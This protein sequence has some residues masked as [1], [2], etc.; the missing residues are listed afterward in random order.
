MDGL[1]KK[2]I[3]EHNPNQA[4]SRIRIEVKAFMKSSLRA[5]SRILCL[6]VSVSF[7]LVS[8]LA[9]LGDS[10]R[11]G[12]LDRRGPWGAFLGGMAIMKEPAIVLWNTSNV[13]M[14]S[15]M[16]MRGR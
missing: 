16:A 3:D 11:S 12:G 9:R 8:G 2:T 4:V 1:V 10:V 6:Y 15:Q 13:T 5:T 14:E 7:L